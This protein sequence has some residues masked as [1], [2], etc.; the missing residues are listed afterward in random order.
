VGERKTITFSMEKEAYKVA[1]KV[2]DKKIAIDEGVNELQK[3]DWNKNA[4]KDYIVDF[5]CLVNGDR[6]QRGIRICRHFMY[7]LSQIFDDYKNDER[8]LYDNA[9]SALEKHNDHVFGDKEGKN[10]QTHIL[11]YNELKK[12]DSFIKEIC[13]HYIEKSEWFKDEDLILYINN[14]KDSI[15][16]KKKLNPKPNISVNRKSP[17]SKPSVSKKI[18][19]QTYK[20]IV[21]KAKDLIILIN[22]YRTKNSMKPVFKE[23]GILKL[24]RDI[25][26]MCES[27]SSFVIF[28]KSLY[29]LFREKTRDKN[30]DYKNK[31]D[32]YYIY[33]FPDIFWEKD[34]ITKRSMDN[35]CII[36]NNYFHSDEDEQ[37]SKSQKLEKRSFLDVVYELTL[38]EQQLPEFKK[39]FQEFQF[40]IMKQFE[41]AM[42]E[43][44]QMVKDDLNPPKKPLNP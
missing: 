20:K 19:S 11:L 42:K 23:S 3:K 17:D 21:Q 26:N 40:K 31:N 22:E 14:Q 9:L 44:L 28:I 43:L 37:D 24:W 29:I 33:R 13:R 1:K 30:Q 15:A 10:N 39:D 12:D 2:Y 16:S 18:S 7:Y 6:P 34:K 25:E 36:R 38:K 35:I 32:H 27:D 8:K 5:R 4:A 41:E